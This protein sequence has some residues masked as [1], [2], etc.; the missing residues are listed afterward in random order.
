MPSG[1]SVPVAKYRSSLPSL[2]QSN[3]ATPEPFAVGACR[4]SVMPEKWTKSIPA[5]WAISANRKGLGA[6]GRPVF[7][8]V[9]TSSVPASVRIETAM[10]SSLGGWADRLGSARKPMANK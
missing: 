5:W 1:K 6:C 2:S 3:M 7:S 10:G 8:R 9:E 4:S